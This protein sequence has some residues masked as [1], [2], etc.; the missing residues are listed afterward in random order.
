MTEGKS[1]RQ[2]ETP[3]LESG[4]Y[5]L[6]EDA[7]RLG[8]GVATINDLPRRV[9][10]PAAASPSHLYNAPYTVV[11]LHTFLMQRGRKGSDSGQSGT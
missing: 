5:P 4:T 6:P 2:G 7:C 3:A 8:I 1:H 10:V 11:L 9:A